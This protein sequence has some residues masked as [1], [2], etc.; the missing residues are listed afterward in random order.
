MLRMPGSLSAHRLQPSLP[1]LPAVDLAWRSGLISGLVTIS[2]GGPWEIVSPGP[3]PPEC[4]CVYPP[5]CQLAEENPHHLRLGPAPSHFPRT[6]TQWQKPAPCMQFRQER[7]SVRFR[8]GHSP[9]SDIFIHFP[10]AR[11]S[12]SILPG[13][14]TIP[15]AFGQV[16]PAGKIR[17]RQPGPWPV[18]L[19]SMT[20]SRFSPFRLCFPPPFAS[21]KIL[22]RLRRCP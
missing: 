10:T 15:E 6:Q 8:T 1:S 13:V 20:L 16:G 12:G 19:W 7:R 18:I 14:Y 17:I 21:A 4:K 11:G 22:G 2:H 5:W 3:L 9:C